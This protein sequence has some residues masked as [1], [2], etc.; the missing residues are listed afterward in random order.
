M[1]GCL[2]HL[3]AA[4][5]R[6]GDE[7]RAAGRLTR[8]RLCPTPIGRCSL[9]PRPLPT[10]PTS[11]LTCSLACPRPMRPWPTCW[12]KLR[13]PRCRNSIAAVAARRRGRA[14]DGELGDSGSFSDNRGVYTSRPQCRVLAPRRAHSLRREGPHPALP[15][16]EWVAGD[17]SASRLGERQFDIVV[18]AYSLTEL[19]DARI[20]EAALGLWGRCAGALVSSSSPAAPA[21]TSG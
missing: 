4:I 18:A 2:R 12:P 20:V 16:A 14:G 1:S 6:T 7:G 8:R 11:R 3:P 10:V 13:R 9:R 19:P 17:L 5:D 15:T 21:T